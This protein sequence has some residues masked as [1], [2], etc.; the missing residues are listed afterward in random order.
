M[1]IGIAYLVAT[2]TGGALLVGALVMGGDD[3]DAD[4][5]G[6]HDGDDGAESD[7]L[8]DVWLPFASLRFWTFV[9]AFG[10]L[11]G[12]LLTWLDLAPAW[13]V[14]LM[15]LVVGWISGAGVS[16]AIR[17]LRRDD[18]NSELRAGDFVGTSAKVLLPVARGRVGKVR[19][20]MGGRSV[21]AIAQT[22]DDDEL[23]PGGEVLVYEVRE[24]GVVLVTREEKRRRVES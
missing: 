11:T 7:G 17:R 24:D 20:E 8:L 23:A 1:G 18:V 13:A 2:L 22:E 3:T 6:D 10:G 19:F 4:G 16:W 5:D 21:D 12:T 15:S 9:F 14:A